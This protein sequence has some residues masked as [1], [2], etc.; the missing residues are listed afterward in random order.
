[1]TPELWDKLAEYGYYAAVAGANIFVVLYWVLAPW[2]RTPFGR[3]LFSFM[4]VIALVLNHG[5][6]A[7]IWET[8]AMSNW[9]NP[10]RAIL[11][12]A[13]AGVIFWRVG[14]L[15]SV[16]FQNRRRRGP[17]EPNSSEKTSRWR[18]RDLDNPDAAHAVVVERVDSLGS[19]HERMGERRRSLLGIPGGARRGLEWP[20]Y[21]Y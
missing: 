13:T 7:R 17:G 4:F 21:F 10:V 14:I 18:D 8:Y 16:Q 15:L 11:L 1:M 5:V 9:I 20:L 3:H 6:V 2:W 19:H 12:W